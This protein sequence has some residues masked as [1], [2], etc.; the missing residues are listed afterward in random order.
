M[1]RESMSR[2]STVG[3]SRRPSLSG[4]KLTAVERLQQARGIVPGA[5]RVESADVLPT[6]NPDSDEMG[7]V[8][9]EEVFMSMKE[10]VVTYGQELQTIQETLDEALT[11]VW[12]VTRDPIGLDY[13]PKEFVELSELL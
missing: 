10:T 2:S 7:S 1:S 8:P 11:E 5:E 9:A 6:F 4:R 13:Q 12:D 3:D